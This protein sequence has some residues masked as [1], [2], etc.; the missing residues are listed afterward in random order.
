MRTDAEVKRWAWE[1]RPGEREPVPHV[2]EHVL[3]RPED[4]AEPVPAVVTAVQDMRRHNDGHGGGDPDPH[5]WDEYG[6]PR[7]DPWPWVTM[8]IGDDP[9][10][11][12]EVKSKEAR[13]RGSAGWLRP[14]SRWHDRKD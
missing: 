13:A 9:H 5:V 10:S 7:P 6:L 12:R 3:F 14:G 2:G 1:R 11:G 4:W 8:R